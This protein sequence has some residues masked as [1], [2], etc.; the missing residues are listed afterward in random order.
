[1]GGITVYII[2]EEEGEA[3]KNWE[4]VHCGAGIFFETLRNITINLRMFW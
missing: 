2:R 4:G 1:V 3:G